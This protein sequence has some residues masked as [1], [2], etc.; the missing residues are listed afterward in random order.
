[1]AKKVLFIDRDGTIIR[2]PE[3]LQIDCFE[4]LEFMPAVINSLAKIAA[5][6]EFELVM[7]SNQDGLGSPSFP[8]EA[9][10]PV[11]NFILNTLKGEGIVF[12]DIFI[13]SSFEHE[14]KATRKPGTAMLHKYIFGD[15]DLE[16]SFVIGDRETDVELARNLGTKSLFIGTR[17]LDGPCL[18]T[19]DWNSIYRYLKAVS[20]TAVIRRKTLETDVFV[21]IN[22][23]GN[24]KCEISTGLSFLDH[25]L[26]QVSKHANLDL[27]V[28][29][30]GDLCIDEHHTVEDTALTLGAAVAKALG[31]KKAIERYGF[32]LPMDD[33]LAQAAIDFSGRP[34][35]LWD[36]V[37]NREKVGDVPTELFSHFFRSFCDEARCNLHLRAEGENEH[38]KI[39]AL[40]KAFARAL[41]DAVKKTDHYQIP[42]TKGTL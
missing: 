22:L 20:R 42:S 31:S 15:Y 34:F 10:Y 28:K 17:T 4:K 21:K 38:H 2:E 29:V 24:G 1:M 35:L 40:F 25:M 5:E 13:D 12:T 6:L 8:E 41:K 16:N 11:Q 32:L 30:K 18:T 39:E 7:V 19:T 37:F 27:E 33:C 3:D 9:F 26:E 14:Q 36:A 23:D